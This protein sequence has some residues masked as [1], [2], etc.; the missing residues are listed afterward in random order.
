MLLQSSQTQAEQA[1]IAVRNS[2]SRSSR[3]L[4]WWMRMAAI[5]LWFAICSVIWMPISF[6]MYRDPRNNT[7]F[8]RFLVPLA[9]KILGLKVVN[10]GVENIPNNEACIF[11]MNHQSNLDVLLNV[12]FYPERCLVIAKRELAFIPV[13]GWLF[14][15]AGN[16]LLK[17]SNKATSKKKMSESGIYISEK[18][19]S[20]W[21][22]PEGTRSK[23]KGLGPFKKG[24]FHLASETGAAL[25]PVVASDYV[26]KLNF[27]RWNS[28]TVTMR[29]LKPLR[30]TWDQVGAVDE[31]NKKVHALMGEAIA[32]ST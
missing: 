17:R 5:G 18:K 30:E 2:S 21:I 16:I 20:I 4:L 25:V 6:V 1:Q 31:V 10:I 29:I 23:G 28:G 26:G 32:E 8:I 13:F 27:S 14:F 22:F 11:L 7:R 15:F 24:A 9:R 12:D 3:N 19:V